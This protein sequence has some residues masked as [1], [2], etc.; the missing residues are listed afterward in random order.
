[1]RISRV[2]PAL[3]LPSVLIPGAAP[4]ARAQ[5]LALDTVEVASGLVQPV[6]MT[7]PPDDSGRLFVVQQT[8]EILIRD[9]VG[10]R[11]TPFL[12]LSS[13]V[14][15]CGERGL[16]GLVFHPEYAT[17]GELFVSYTRT[18][19]SQL[20]TVVA[21]YTVS[22]ADPDLADPASEEVLLAMDQPGNNHNG[23]QLAF[24]PD[25]F[26]YISTGD[27]SGGGGADAHENG[28]SLA[29]LLG[30]ILRI[31][32]DSTDPGVAYAIPPDNPFVGVAGAREEI[33]AYG[34][35]NPWRASF[36]R[37]TG[38][39]WIADVGSQAWEEID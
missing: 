17:N 22:A 26:L 2:W 3:L 14:T 18:V 13:V 33:W 30:K 28:Q 12:D 11:P 7:A 15:C 36:D 16:L 8:G 4:S 20:Q 38:D 32:V 31:D 1:M 19:D 23:G 21:R 34:L 37:W 6:A 35:R 9:A 5:G 10:V 24:G 39:L 25:G 27:G 29:T